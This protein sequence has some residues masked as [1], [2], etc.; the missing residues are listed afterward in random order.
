MDGGD[1]DEVL[2]ENQ[3]GG[4]ASPQRVARPHGEGGLHVVA[5]EMKC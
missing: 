3:V 5:N 1:N 4:G 2:T